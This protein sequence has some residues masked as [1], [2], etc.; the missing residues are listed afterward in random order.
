V[1][2]LS[3][4]VEKEIEDVKIQ[5]VEYRIFQFLLFG[6]KFLVSLGVNSITAWLTQASDRVNS[7]RAKRSP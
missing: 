4:G 2:A 6:F 1:I 7:G 5:S 3:H